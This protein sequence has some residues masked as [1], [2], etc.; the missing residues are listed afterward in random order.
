LVK[1]KSIAAVYEEAFA[2]KPF[3]RQLP[4]I[5][6]GHAY[7]LFVSEFENRDGLIQHLRNKNIMA[8]VHYIPVHLM[9]YYRQFGWKEGDMPVAEKYYQHC[10]SLPIYPTLTEEEQAFVIKT[11]EEFYGA[12]R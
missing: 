4:G 10:L 6:E 5:V 9:P 2:G 8:Q 7:H 11:I 3:I 1:R 12:D